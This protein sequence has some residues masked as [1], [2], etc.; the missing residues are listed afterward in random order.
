MSS[1][2]AIGNGTLIDW[3]HQ[4]SK[5][6]SILEKAIS[7]SARPRKRK[8]KSKERNESDKIFRFVRP[9][10][11]CSFV[12]FHN[13]TTTTLNGAQL[14]HNRASACDDCEKAEKDTNIVS[15]YP[16]KMAEKTKKKRRREAEFNNK[17]A[18]ETRES[19]PFSTSGAPKTVEGQ[20]LNCPF[21]SIL[22]YCA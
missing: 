19:F 16:L 8:N 1:L 11:S 20:P 18:D 14:F 5:M 12:L 3:Q 10:A 22:L 21:L 9:F 15:S 2:D 4:K 13:R 7:R 17:W 6:H